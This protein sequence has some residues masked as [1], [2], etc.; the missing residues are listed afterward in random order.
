MLRIPSEYVHP[1]A[2]I[3]AI[4][5]AEAWNMQI[6]QKARYSS[7]TTDFSVRHTDHPTHSE[8]E[9]AS[10]LHFVLLRPVKNL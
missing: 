10:I 6:S 8:I 1:L 4:P 7:I 9:N 2:L 5:L 3:S